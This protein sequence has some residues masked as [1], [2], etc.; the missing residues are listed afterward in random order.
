MK[1]DIVIVKFH[2]AELLGFRSGGVALIAVKPIAAAMGLD[3]PSQ[4]KRIQRDPILSAGIVMMTIPFGAGGPQ[5]MVCL[6]DLIHG[7]L[8]KLDSTRIKVGIRESIQVFQRECYS[9]LSEHFF[10]DHDL[11][12]ENETMRLSRFIYSMPTKRP[13]KG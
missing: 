11:R 3:W 7:W 5:E 4:Y 6:D 10:D 8:F 1:N 9:V 2:G 13:V 12:A